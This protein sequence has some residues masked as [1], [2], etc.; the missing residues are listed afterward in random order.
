M[1]A[2]VLCGSFPGHKRPNKKT[3][4]FG[5]RSVLKCWGPDVSLDYI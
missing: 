4:S 2:V 3:A 1:P 5:D